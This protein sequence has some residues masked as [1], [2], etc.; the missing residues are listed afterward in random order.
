MLVLYFAVLILMFEQNMFLI[1]TPFL[2][3]SVTF[4][5]QQKGGCG[6]IE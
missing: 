1:M 5:L 4:S 3:E 2:L 6:V